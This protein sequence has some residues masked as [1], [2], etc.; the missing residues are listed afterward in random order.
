MG[1]RP[2]Q[3]KF[4]GI[5]EV[6][7]QSKGMGDTWTKMILA[8]IDIAFPDLRLLTERCEVGRGAI[9]GLKRLLPDPRGA[10]LANQ[11]SQELLMFVTRVVNARGDAVSN[12][13]QFCD[14]LSN[15][16]AFACTKF[17]NFPL[18]VRHMNTTRHELGAGTVQVQLCEWRQ[19][20]GRP[21]KGLSPQD[22]TDGNRQPGGAVRHALCDSSC[23]PQGPPK[24]DRPD[25]ADDLQ[26]RI[27]KSCRKSQGSPS[28]V[29]C[30]GDIE[31]PSATATELCRLWEGEQKTLHDRRQ[32]MQKP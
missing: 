27:S 11:T 20:H 2:P 26:G 8:S 13:S 17:G 18:V 32:S 25:Q 15:I 7:R 19:F 4:S 16:E 30:S 23:R 9:D 21:R 28:Q 6:V 22:N 3:K 1:L 10:H 24:R 5:S 29:L 31:M 14:L 12:R